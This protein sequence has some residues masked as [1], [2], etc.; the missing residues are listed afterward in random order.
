MRRRRRP[1]SPWLV[2]EQNLTFA[3]RTAD[4]YLV[5]DQGRSVLEGSPATVDRDRILVHLHV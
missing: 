3:E 1:A 2:V 4:R 5:M